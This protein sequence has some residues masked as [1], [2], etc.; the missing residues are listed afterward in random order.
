MGV[1]VLAR[2]TTTPLSALEAKLASLGATPHAGRWKTE[3]RYL[4]DPT[5]AAAATTAGAAASGLNDLF[6]VTIDAFGISA[7][8]GGGG[9]AERLIVMGG[10]GT[11]AQPAASSAVVRV[12]RAGVGIGSILDAC[13]THV[14][15]TYVRVEGKEVWFC[16][17]FVVRLGQLFVNQKERGTA[18]EVRSRSQAAKQPQPRTATA[19]KQRTLTLSLSLSRNA[20]VEYLPCTQGETACLPLHALLEVLLPSSERDWSSSSSSSSSSSAAAAAPL[21]TTAA[22]AADGASDSSGGRLRQTVAADGASAAAAQQQQAVLDGFGS[23]AC[24]LPAVYGPEHTALLVVG[25]M[26]ARLLAAG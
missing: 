16:G 23:A 22:A 7:D 1:R 5:V 2:T 12:L 17:D 26:R 25:L 14:P 3:V 18:V 21:Y 20:Q 19:A 9:T 8:G 15:R 24:D 6:D 11:S 10:G 13:K 4:R